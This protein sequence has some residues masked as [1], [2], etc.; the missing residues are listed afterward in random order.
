M[1]EADTTDR[2]SWLV[3]VVLGSIGVL[4]IAAPF[5]AGSSGLAIMFAFFVG[6]AFLA[7]ALGVLS[8]VLTGE[9]PPIR[10]GG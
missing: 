10:K 5:A 6:T 8:P 1:A 2:T 9:H 3:A 7:G 4:V